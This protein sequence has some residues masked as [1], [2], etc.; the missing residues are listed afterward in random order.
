MANKPIHL[1]MKAKNPSGRQAMWEA[2]RSNK[3]G[4]TLTGLTN[5]FSDLKRETLRTYIRALIAGGYVVK[6]TEGDVKTPTIFKLAKDVGVNA[7]NVNSKG[8]LSK[9]GNGTQQMWHAMRILKKFSYTDLSV[10]ASTEETPVSILTAKAY[11]KTLCKAGYLRR[12]KE[13][14]YC[15][16]ASR[17]TGP[18]APMIQRLK[19]VFDPNLQKIVWQQEANDD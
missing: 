4:F 6:A 19:T 14:L 18:R 11:A 8:E 9:L 12:E 1:R 3:D 13:G 2:I 10:T 5:S 7:P 16:I 17:Y 15:F